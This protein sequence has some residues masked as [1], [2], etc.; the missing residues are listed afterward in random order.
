MSHIQSFCDQESSLVQTLNADAWGSGSH[1]LVVDDSKVTRAILGEMLQESGHSVLFASDGLEALEILEQYGLGVALVLLDRMMPNLDG[2]EVLT[3]MKQHKDWEHIPVIMQTAATADEDIRSGIAAGAFYY[4]T[5]PFHEEAVRGI[6]N[7]T[8]KDARQRQAWREEFQWECQALGCL[9][10]ASFQIRTLDEVA[11][12]ARLL[13][14][15]CPQ[16][17][18]IC[19]GLA[20]LLVNGVE[21]GNLAISYDEKTELQREARWE[22]EIRMRLEQEPYA[23]RF[24]TVDFEQC[25]DWIHVTIR[26]QGAGFNW[27][28]FLDFDPSMAFA[29]HGRGIAMAKSLCFDELEY[30][31]NGNVVRC[32]IAKQNQAVTPK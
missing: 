1:I 28:P 13:A 18:Q 8:L 30:S 15:A 32:G 5:K 24:V 9:K 12:L 17:D 27:K 22:Q 11:S 31:G 29:T 10:T 25:S 3:R 7:A 16:P 21:H 4:L 2:I 6:V 20:D 23:S 26:D 14:N 19:V